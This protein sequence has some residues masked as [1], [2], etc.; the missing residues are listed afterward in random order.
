M[1]ASSC[2]T[3]E[4]DA[5]LGRTVANSFSAALTVVRGSERLGAAWRPHGISGERVLVWRA[6]LD[7][8]RGTS[9]SSRS[10]RA[11]SEVICASGSSNEAGLDGPPPELPSVAG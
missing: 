10:K 8:R 5:E 6:G 4:L 7:A 11:I 9:S 2:G 3:I 1:S